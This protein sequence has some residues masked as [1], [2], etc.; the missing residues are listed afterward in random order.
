MTVHIE[1]QR[2]DSPASRILKLLRQR[3]PCTIKAMVEGLGVTATAVRQQLSTL[4]AQGLVMTA[5]VRDGR[6]RPPAVYHLSEKGKG[7]STRP[8]DSLALVLLEEIL[9]MGRARRDVA[10]TQ[11]VAAFELGNEPALRRASTR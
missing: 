11:R 9:A 6:G 8:S 2:D 10:A 7:L 1:L 4:M 3:G 5:A